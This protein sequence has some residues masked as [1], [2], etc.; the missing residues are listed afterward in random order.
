MSFAFKFA[1]AARR[2]LYIGLAATLAV[3]PGC[4]K[5]GTSESG[6]TAD[7]KPTLIAEATAKLNAAGE[8]V[9]ALKEVE[10]WVLTQIK[11]PS[12]GDEVPLLKNART[13]VVDKITSSFATIASNLAASGDA[14][15]LKKLIGW[16]DDTI[17]A[18]EALAEAERAGYAQKFERP[19]RELWRALLTVEPANLD[20]RKKLGYV[21]I[22]EDFETAL[23]ADWMDDDVLIDEIVA[24][25][26]QL[27]TVEKSTDGK[28]WLPADS[29]HIT[30]I[31]SVEK[32]I[33]ALKKDFETRMA[34]PF[35]K[36]A[37]ETGLQA[38]DDT[39]K[40]LK[41]TAYKWTVR[42]V[43]PYVI[44]VERDKSWNEEA[45]A[46]ERAGQLLD[47]Y[48]D[49]YANYR[50]VLG[51]DDIKKPVPVVV[52]RK[53][54]AYQVF[55]SKQNMGQGAAGHF[56]HM[57]GRLYLSDETG[58]DT[59]LHEG[60]HQIIAF[61]SVGGTANFMNRPYWFEE[62]IAEFFGAAHR[63]TD[64]VTKEQRW[65]VGNRLQEER[66]DYWRQ[67][68][69]SAYKLKDLVG[70][71]MRDREKNKASDN[72]T[73][74]LFAY[75]QG[76]FL[77]FFLNNYNVDS[78]G[79]VQVGKEGKYKKQWLDFFKRCINGDTSRE[80]FF[81]CFGLMKNGKLDEEGYAK[82]E[83][84]YLDYFD[85]VN[86][87]RAMKYHV[88]DRELVPWNQVKNRAGADVGAIEDDLLKP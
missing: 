57:T 68:E 21:E 76:W 87:K 75:S 66:L 33:D 63:E 65:R 56:S 67:N 15:K 45:V 43:P 44:I 25:K 8:N 24:L 12:A 38:A 88:K 40:E 62:G 46:K 85:F 39:T 9:K 70:L 86:R 49:F 83:R 27:A 52:F 74:N 84:E 22:D 7:A 34:D 82:L 69:K 35:Q 55:A 26:S 64:P 54:N 53:H 73:Q 48:R 80:T 29:K 41:N 11:S 50:T 16:A 78:K 3:A 36:S 71:T 13:A 30:E 14:E 6:T 81:D 23:G 77:I 1:G 32:R 37:W 2:I 60:T 28:R 47:L 79:V 19:T 58:T 5:K 4:G 59:L 72:E 17:K 61:N 51:L 10:D 42:C 20:A 31:E 18:D